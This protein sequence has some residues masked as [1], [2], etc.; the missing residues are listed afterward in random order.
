VNSESFGPCPARELAPPVVAHLITSAP[1]RTIVRTVVRTASP[2]SATLGG[3]L[4]SLSA[5]ALWPDGLT[6]SPRPPVG[7]MIA[8]DST[9]RGPEI[10]P[11]W[12]A[13]R[14]PASSPPASRIAV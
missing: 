14:K 10:N 6:R 11:S 4:G 1:A 5:G 13:T 7:E 12:M 8:S 2:P 9:S 3:R